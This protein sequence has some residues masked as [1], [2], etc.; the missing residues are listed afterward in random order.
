VAFA[1]NL[2]LRGGWG[3]GIEVE[4]R[5]PNR[6][7]DLDS[8]DAQAVSRGYFR[9]LGIP[10]L[11]GRGFEE[12]DREGAAYVGLVNQEFERV[13]L[14]GETALGKRFRRGDWAPWVAVVGVVASLRRDGRAAERTPQIYLPAAQT[15]I[16]PVNLADVAVRGRG[17][18]EAF[19]ALLR[20]DVAGL[21]PE[22]PISRVMT[23]DDAIARDLAPRRFGLAL[24]AG[25]AV[26]ALALTLVGIYGVA[27][28]SVSQRV[29]ELGVRLALGAG[30]SRILRLVV[31]DV[32]GQVLA[33]ILIG[34]GLSLLATRA[35]KSL[36]FQ[37]APIDP[38]S[39]AVV[40]VLLALAGLAAALG[41]GLRAARVDPVAALRWE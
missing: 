27:A 23:L 17:G 9:T 24:L 14:A 25:F 16:Y 19:S 4:G 37:V 28:Y 31:G 33:G 38:G 13:F 6:P 34:L 26:T 30:R 1:S 10:L 11:R 5:P 41:P 2:P 39:Y 29:P 22:Q 36:L 18:V 3:T 32:L 40:A 12:A 8:A 21:D 15:G 7:G 35:L 20:A